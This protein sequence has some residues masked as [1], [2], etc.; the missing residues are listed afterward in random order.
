MHEKAISDFVKDLE[1]ANFMAS[2]LSVAMDF[3]CDGYQ[4]TANLM[5]EHLVSME[6]KKIRHPNM[7]ALWNLL[8]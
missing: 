8:A 5:I 4:C 7:G 1:N 6:S 2:N 3:W